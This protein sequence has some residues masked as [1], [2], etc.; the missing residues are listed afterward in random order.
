[1]T[2]DKKF[3]SYRIYSPDISSGKN[4]FVEWYEGKK[5]VRKYGDINQHKTHAERMEAIES[6]IYTYRLRDHKGRDLAVKEKAY[7]YLAENRGVWRKKSYQTFKSKLDTFYSIHGESKPTEDSVKKFFGWLKSK[8][9]KT[10][11]NS[12]Q[13]ALKMIFEAIGEGRAFEG[14]KRI[15]SI[16]T[17]ARYF[18]TYQIKRLKNAMQENDPELWLFVQFQYYCFIRPNSEL[19]LLKVGDLLLDDNKILVRSDISKN[20]KSEYVSI[21]DAFR[22]RLKDFREKSPAEF[23]FPNPDDPYKPRGYNYFSNKHRKLLKSLGFDKAY[24]LYSW[25]HT[26]AVACVKAGVGVKELQIQLRHYS[27]EEVDK[28]LRQLGVTDLARL[29][30]SFP[31]I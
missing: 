7:L 3:L 17:P 30:R 8:R 1:M 15:R 10:T 4:W 20:G 2:I 9:H 24:K 31:G 28:Y 12:Y 18:Q 22:C 25:K 5:R 26:G 29:E 21:P 19:R 13:Q 27:L 11:F 14:V 6:I 23:L 16:K